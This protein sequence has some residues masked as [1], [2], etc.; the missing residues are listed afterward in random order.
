MESEIVR[1]QAILLLGPTG[2][3]KT[4]LGE[5]IEAGGL[6]GRRCGHFDFGERLRRVAAEQLEVPELTD[7]DRAFITDV[8]DGGVLLEDEHFHVAEKILGAF[9]AERNVGPGDWIVLNGLPRHVG[10]AGDVGRIVA[11]HGV[12]ELACT[13]ETV[14]ARLAGNAGGD[15]AGR[16]DDDL[17]RVRK[18]LEIYAARTEPLLAHYERLGVHVVTVAVGPDTTAQD[19]RQALCRGP[20]PTDL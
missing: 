13:P 1:P 12:I 14:L 20:R 19:V 8:L 4:P 17:A 11:V 7:G 2:S 10:Q 18:K 16:T 3:G 15:R 9:L 6:A 5:A